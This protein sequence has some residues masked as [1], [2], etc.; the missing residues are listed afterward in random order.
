MNWPSLSNECSEAIADV[1]KDAVQARPKDLFEYVAQKLQERSGLSASAFE[2]LFHDCKAKPKTYVLEERCP[3]AKDP[4]A[5]V[6][7]RYNDDTGLMMLRHLTQ[8]LLG[9]M[10]SAD[11]NIDGHGLYGR[12]SC[13]FPEFQY[14]RGFVQEFQAIQSI[15]ALFLM[16][17]NEGSVAAGLEDADAKLSFRCQGLIEV[18]RSQ[19]QLL[20]PSMLE[21]L[22]VCIMMQALGDHA[23]FCARYG[24]GLSGQRKGSL[25]ACEHHAAALPS[26]RRLAAPQ[27]ALVLKVIEAYVSLS[28]IVSTEAVG[29]HFLR[30]KDSLAAHPKG[31]ELYIGAA[32]IEYAVQNRS[33]VFSADM[34]DAARAATQCVAELQ[35]ASAPRAYELLLK[36]RAEKHQWRVVRDDFLLKAV[37]RLC[38]MAGLEETSSWEEV[39]QFVDALADSEKEMLQLELGAMDG[40]TQSPAC[41]LSGASDVLQQAAKLKRETL[42]SGRVIRMFL[43]ILEDTVR[44]CQRMQHLR[45]ITIVINELSEYV[46]GMSEGMPFEDLPFSLV[47]TGPGEMALVLPRDNW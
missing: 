4:F 36:R 9:D 14:L 44:T 17:C 37:V 20:D 29:L 11:F 3:V 40:I 5:W 22:V 38:C 23:G 25:F 30:L 34:V 26:Y 7:V 16:C 21:T 12:A 28:S 45:T 24:G 33:R 39:L 13:C 42:T 1:L 18:I 46:R 8:D 41:I 6:G 31:L 27:Q 32:G 35:R 10:L 15:R 2:A 43:R 47:E 19:F